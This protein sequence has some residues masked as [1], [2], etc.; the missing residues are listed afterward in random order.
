[1]R[2]P[3]RSAG[4]SCDLHLTC[5]ALSRRAVRGPPRAPHRRPGRSPPPRT[6]R[7]VPWPEERPGRPGRPPSCRE[8][9]GSAPVRGCWPT[10][11][12]GSH[13]VAGRG[14]GG[15]AGAGVGRWSGGLRSRVWAVWHAHPWGVR[16]VAGH[17]AGGTG[18]YLGRDTAMNTTA[19][20]PD[21]L[22]E[23]MLNIV[24]E[25]MDV[26][27]CSYSQGVSYKLVD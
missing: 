23:L 13:E 5:R 16:S 27:S 8:L 19:I 17:R 9:V 12:R 2:S 22:I 10:N 21:R 15:G 18:P 20:K 25:F 7:G 1:R 11:W 3:S 6:G 24:V 4:G 26:S 14:R